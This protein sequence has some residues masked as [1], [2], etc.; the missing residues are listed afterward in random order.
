M[1]F[2]DAADPPPPGPEFSHLVTVETLRDRGEAK[3]SAS[4]TPEECAALAR[5]FNVHSVESLAFDAEIVPAADGWKAMGE[6]RAALTQLCGVTLEPVAETIAERFERRFVAGAPT[7]APAHELDMRGEDDPD[8]LGAAI[9][10]GE[11]AAEM[12]A[13]AIDPWPRAPGVAFEG[14]RSGPPGAEALT[15]EAARP[16]AGLA[17][18]KKRMEEE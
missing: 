4:A 17:A 14:A 12:A 3:L 11:L 10:L 9:D 18:L 8:A 7:R 2:S 13:L 6:V 15:D 5:R 16:F 1:T